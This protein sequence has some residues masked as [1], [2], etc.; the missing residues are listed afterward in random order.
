[1][2]SKSQLFSRWFQF[3]CPAFRQ[4]FSFFQESW[5]PSRMLHLQLLHIMTHS[6]MRSNKTKS[7]VFSLERLYKVC[8]KKILGPKNILSE[9]NFPT[10][11]S[12]ENFWS[13]K[14][15]CLKKF[16]FKNFFGTNKIVGLKILGQQK[17]WIW[18]KI[19]FKKKF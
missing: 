18:K 9:N 5:T 4:I 16:W 13:E 8:I 12:S 17:I 19:G 14:K 7:K 1:M 6:Q 11:F 2:K 10:K 15:F 3:S